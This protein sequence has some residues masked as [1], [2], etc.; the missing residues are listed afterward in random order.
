MNFLPNHRRA[1]T[2]IELLVVIAI[3]A[4]LIALLLP[5]VQKVREAANRMMCG[6]NLRQLGVAAHNYH[7][8]YNRLP[9][10]YYGP[11]RANGG[12]TIYNA[13]RGPWVGCLVPLLP[14]LEQDN[15]FKQLCASTQTWP[16]PDPGTAG[17]PPISLGLGQENAAWWTVTGNLQPGTGQAQ[18]K[19]FRCPSDTLGS[20]QVTSPIV[21]IHIANGTIR[22]A[23]AHGVPYL[24]YTN[25][26]GVAGTAG[27][28]DNPAATAPF[29][30]FEGVLFNRSQITLGQITVLDGTSNTLLFGETLGGQGVAGRDFAY[31]WFGCGALG[32]GW[33]LGNP[34][35]PAPGHDPPALGTAPAAGTEG[36][37]WYRFSSW[38][39]AGVQFCF[40]DGS[41][42]L[43]HFGTTTQPSLAGNGDNGSDWA[44]LQQL[45][46]RKD[47]YLQDP[48][49][50]ME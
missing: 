42:R 30:R 21:T 48:A 31:A 5:A 50:L 8:D 6:N 2:L 25:Y 7:S 27:D 4:L 11:V 38:H 33:G 37:S 14:Y 41:V 15:L 44:V 22:H 23:H 13:N 32:T 47:G 28:S 16:G 34:R 9:P 10:G 46:G 19:M 49:A 20:E 18:W 45:A 1:F 24:G 36:A 26:V 39:P 35:V 3:I 29:S 43:I 12:N 17:A 40:C